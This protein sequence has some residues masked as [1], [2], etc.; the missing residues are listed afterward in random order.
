MVD[1]SGGRGFEQATPMHRTESIR[2]PHINKQKME[3]GIPFDTITRNDEK[4][5]H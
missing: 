3:G 1:D 2:L 4:S 5:T